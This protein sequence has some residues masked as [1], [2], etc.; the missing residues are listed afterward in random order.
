MWN[1]DAENYKMLMREIEED[2]NRLI[3]SVKLKI[4][5]RY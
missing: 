4:Q 3:M 5:E 1:L 2:V